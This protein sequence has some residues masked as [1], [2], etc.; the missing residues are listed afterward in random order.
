MWLPGSG[1]DTQ[2]RKGYYAPK[3][4]SD[5]EKTA[6]EGQSRCSQSCLQ[7]A[8]VGQTSVC[9]GLQAASRKR[10]KTRGRRTKVRGPLWGGLKPAPPNMD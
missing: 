9:G 5:A 8:F 7:P 3:K 6:K 2:A 4:L 1:T 10:C